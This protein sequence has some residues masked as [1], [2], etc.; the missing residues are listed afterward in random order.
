MIKKFRCI[1]IKIREQFHSIDVQNLF[2]DLYMEFFFLVIQ[3][4]WKKIFSSFSLKSDY[5]MKKVII[6]IN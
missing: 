2:Y 5:L 3:I 4:K 6:K 1:L